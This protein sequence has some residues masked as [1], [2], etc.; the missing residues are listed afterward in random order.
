MHADTL[1][2]PPKG[3][4][5]RFSVPKMLAFSRPLPAI[6]PVEV[7]EMRGSAVSRGLVREVA[8]LDGGIRGSGLNGVGSDLGGTYIWWVT[9]S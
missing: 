4:E 5:S 6:S 8:G 2:W 7:G 1:E 9:C 3:S